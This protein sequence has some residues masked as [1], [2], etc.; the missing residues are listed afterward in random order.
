MKCHVSQRDMSVSTE[1]QNDESH[2]D[3]NCIQ[4]EKTTVPRYDQRINA[5]GAQEFLRTIRVKTA[6]VAD[7]NR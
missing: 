6:A 5:L 1:Q 7:S 2:C 3:D 4:H